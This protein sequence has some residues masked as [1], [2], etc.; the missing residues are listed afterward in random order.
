MNP[1]KIW[2]S[3]TAAEPW[4]SRTAAPGLLARGISAEQHKSPRAASS[5]TSAEQPKSPDASAPD[6]LVLGEPKQA[7][8][9]F[10]GCFN[11]L[12]MVSLERLSDGDRARVLDG[13]FGPDGAN[14]TFCRLP[15]G[16][17]DFATRWYSYDET[18]GDLSLERFSIDGDRRYLLPYVEA[19]RQ[20]QPQ[21]RFFSS[22]WSPPTWMKFPAV[23]NHGRLRM[24]APILE[25]YALY[26]LKYLRAYEAE[27]IT[28][29]QVHLQ[30]EPFADQKFP[31]CLWTA[32]QFIVFIRD[33]LG[34]L[35]ERERVKTEIWLGTLN[36]PEIM[37]FSPTGPIVLDPYHQ[38]VEKVLLEP[39][40]RRHLKGVGYQWAGRQNIARTH[41]SFSEL[42]LMQT[43]NECGDGRNTW[44]YA[45]YVFTL[46]QHYLSAGANA[47]IYWNMVLQRGGVSTWGW[48]QNSLVTVSADG[49]AWEFSPEFYVMKHLSR[50]VVPGAVRLDLTGVWASSSLAFR[51]PDGS[52]VVVAAN[53]QDYSRDLAVSGGS[54]SWR[55][56]L[57]PMSI[58]T[59]VF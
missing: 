46:I 14:F 52:V 17:S 24:E 9:G 45:F 18:E 5:G 54:I 12:G 22:P 59:L 19:A 36:G 32:D 38:Y 35:F 30:N 10:G 56:P 15:M 13:L 16:A 58:S 51:N 48:P 42:G 55:G 27:G 25:A 4:R 44:D 20:R 29:E 31:S 21:M 28:V 39:G 2:I 6:T 1:P 43:E 53:F 7:I 11:E 3:T 49:A 47:Y 40:A 8:S 37:K 34:P 41:L 33:Y 50:Y 57:P 26:F 23:Y